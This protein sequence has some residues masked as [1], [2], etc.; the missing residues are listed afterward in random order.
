MM[1]MRIGA[2]SPVQQPAQRPAAQPESD[3]DGALV[4][5]DSFGSQSSH[6]YLVEGAAGS[7]GSTGQVYRYHQHQMVNGKPSLPHVEAV[8]GLVAAFSSAPLAP[9]DAQSR[10][11]TFVDLATGGNLE[12]TTDILKGI[13][14]EGFTHSALNLSQGMD[15]I[16]LLQLAKHGLGKSSNL[17]EEQKAV[18][19]QNL[20]A[21]VGSQG[22][23]LIERDL[24]NLLLQTIKRE[25]GHSP[26]IAQARQHWQHQVEEFESSHNSVVVAAGNSGQAQKALAAAGFDIDGSE[27]VNVFSVP[28]VTVVGATMETDKGATI[29][30]PPSSFGQEVGFLVS[31]Q[32]GE[33]FGTSFASPKVANALRAAHLAN[34]EFTSDQAETWLSQEVS[35]R[36]L[37]E[38]QEV[39]LLD[40]RR[41]NSL[42]RIV[43]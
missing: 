32:Y 23:E 3:K 13:T 5:I 25:V 4:I 9:E 21:V 11:K 40:T 35:D 26:E 8:K 24:D 34:R 30:A 15:P 17:S 28:G 10:F 41:A 16:L 20:T 27:D 18:Y 14:A 1:V 43:S 36:A 39:S 22:N 19:R 33:H 6:G 29:L 38:K 31:G 7:V 12:H 37:V 2:N 42:L